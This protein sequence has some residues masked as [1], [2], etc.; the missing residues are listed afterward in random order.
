[1][2]QWCLGKA[3]DPG[4]GAVVAADDAGRA[5]HPEPFTDRR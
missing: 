1:M 2:V 4:W 3:T 5:E